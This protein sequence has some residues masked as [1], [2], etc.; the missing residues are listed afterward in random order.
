[1]TDLHKT[2]Q[3]ETLIE[4]PCDFELKAMGRHCDEFIDLVFSITQ[5]HVPEVSRDNMRFSASKG[6]R[7]ISVKIKFYATHIGQ[8]HGIYGE[9]NEHPDV[10]MTL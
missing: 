4:F 8:I 7:F 6:Q 2:E 3:P 9:L 5:K 10:L 1:M